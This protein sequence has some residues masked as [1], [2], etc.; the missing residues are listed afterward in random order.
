MLT[1]LGECVQAALSTEGIRGIVT[2]MVAAG[3]VA[4]FFLGRVPPDSYVTVAGI[5]M[6]FWFGRQNRPNG[7]GPSS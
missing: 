5:I 7:S 1:K 3:L 4:G 2:I 6:A